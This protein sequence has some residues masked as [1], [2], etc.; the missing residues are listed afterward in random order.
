LKRFGVVRVSLDKANRIAVVHDLIM[1]FRGVKP[2]LKGPQKGM[3]VCVLPLVVGCVSLACS[4]GSIS[5]LAMQKMARF[6][7]VSHV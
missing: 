2:V 1:I 5:L 3:A 4:S 7:A 6:R